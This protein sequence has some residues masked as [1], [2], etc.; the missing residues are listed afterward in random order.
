MAKMGGSLDFLV[1]GGNV[2][3]DFFFVFNSPPVYVS[4]KML[5]FDA[6]WAVTPRLVCVD[7]I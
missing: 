6:Q 5:A 1:D 7:N 3:N 2:N 4:K